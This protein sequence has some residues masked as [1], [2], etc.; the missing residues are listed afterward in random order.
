MFDG[1]I[2]F[3]QRTSCEEDTSAANDYDYLCFRIDGAEMGRWDGE[4][5][6]TYEHFP[7]T[8]GFHR[9]EWIY[10][11]DQSVNYRFDAAWVDLI[12]FPSAIM[13]S[14]AI[15]TGP[16]SLDFLLRTG[17]LESQALILS[18]PAVGDLNFTA[19]LAGIEPSIKSIPSGGR[20]I[21]GSYLVSNAEKFY[22]GHEYAWNLRTYNGGNDNEWI[23]QIY[24][25]FPAGL[26]LVAASD[27]TGGSGGAMVFQG[28]FG[29]GVI[30]HWFGQ[31]ANG[32]GV[33]HMGETASSDVS[34]VPQSDIQGDIT[35]DYEVDG[36]VYGGTPHIVYGSI[37][38]RNLGPVTPWLS[39]DTT[40]GNLA[41]TT[42]DSLIVTVDAEG[43]ADGKY[44]AWILV[45]DN[46]GSEI[47]V[48][49]NL[50]IDTYMDGPGPIYNQTSD[51]FRAF[52]NP[53]QSLTTFSI[54]VGESSDIKLEISTL[55]GR[56][57]MEFSARVEA[58]ARE[59]INWD[60]K[61]RNGNRVPPG[62]YLGRLYAGDQSYFVKLILTK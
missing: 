52:P 36:E 34:V 58:N 37:P 35:I 54:M 32:W 46:F 48:P 47:V 5:V 26:V 41:G 13:A 39:I 1:D 29:N 31:D 49:V 27:F 4:T 24:V 44:Q 25:S 17:E 9:F 59:Q 8:A 28:P 43:M 40:A 10:R 60:G 6:W 55:E 19:D 38:L 21:E 7:V 11:K 56:V 53:F 45:Q 50:T 2:S 33:V 30:A 15:V 12:T 22:T 23:K 16:A 14:P 3:Y 51:I 61:D 42:T 62:I 18:N 20:N 57:V